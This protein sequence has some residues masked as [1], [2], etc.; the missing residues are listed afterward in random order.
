M[1][2]RPEPDNRVLVQEGRRKESL[3]SKLFILVQLDSYFRRAELVLRCV[4]VAAPQQLLI[5]LLDFTT[6]IT[7][8]A[9][10]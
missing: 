1:G 2:L 4:K 7:E 10:F 8:H 3:Y 9:F 5:S 6:L